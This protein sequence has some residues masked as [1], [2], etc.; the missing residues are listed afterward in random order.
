MDNN[1]KEILDSLPSKRPR[2][3]LEP[4]GDLINELRRRGRTYREI[5]HIL[6]EK[7]GIQVT[8]SGV[9]DFVRRRLRDKRKPAASIASSTAEKRL[10]ARIPRVTTTPESVPSLSRSDNVQLKIAALK[11]RKP[12]VKSSPEKFQFDPSEPLRLKKADRKTPLRST[13]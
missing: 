11:A 2:S 6:D 7:C 13:D 9:H 3:R 12:G 5:G 4:H 8:A 10:S 1:I